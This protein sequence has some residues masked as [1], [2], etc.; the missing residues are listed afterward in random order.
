MMII[1][2]IFKS[3]LVTYRWITHFTSQKQTTA[4]KD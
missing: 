2:W 3:S 1:K 4:N